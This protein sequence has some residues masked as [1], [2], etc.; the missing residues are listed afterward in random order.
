MRTIQTRG[1]VTTDGKLTIDV[2]SAVEPGEHQIVVVIDALP[3][4]E[5]A[6]VAQHGGSFDRLVDEPDLYTDKDG[7]PV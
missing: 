4:E 1:T 7:E 5:L 6:A 3:G 2:P